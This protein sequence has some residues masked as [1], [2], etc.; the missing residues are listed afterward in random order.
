MISSLASAPLK[1]AGSTE[2]RSRRRRRSKGKSFACPVQ[3]VSSTVSVMREAQLI[4]VQLNKNKELEVQR[5]GN[6]ACTNLKGVKMRECECE[7][8]EITSKRFFKCS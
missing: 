1:G 3:S 2:Q 8:R 4:P 5:F 7:I 6:V